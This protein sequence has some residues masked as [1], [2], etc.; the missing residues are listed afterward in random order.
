[1][2]F[3]RKKKERESIKRRM[4]TKAILLCGGLGTRLGELTTFQ[5]KHII[6]IGSY[7]MLYYPLILFKQLG[8]KDVRLITSDYHAGNIFQNL[9]SE[10]FGLNI[11]YGVQKKPDG[12]A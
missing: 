1:M 9:D 10:K 3:R 6:P 12:I 7:P 5:N 4:I 2:F 11:S 8:I